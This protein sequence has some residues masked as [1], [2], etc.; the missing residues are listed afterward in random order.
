M[1]FAIFVYGLS[2]A[3]KRRFETIKIVLRILLYLCIYYNK[4]NKTMSLWQRYEI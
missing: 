2:I 4:K 3:C 1:G